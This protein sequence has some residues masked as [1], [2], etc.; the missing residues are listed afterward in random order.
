V[1][2][3]HAHLPQARSIRVGSAA[4]LRRQA[5]A[6]SSD[7]EI[8]GRIPEA[9]ALRIENRDQLIKSGVLRHTGDVAGLVI[10]K[11]A[12]FPH[13]VAK[14]RFSGLTRTSNDHRSLLLAR[15]VELRRP[16]TSRVPYAGRRRLLGS[17]VLA[18]IA[19]CGGGSVGNSNS[20]VVATKWQRSA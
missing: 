10:P 9:R 13:A 5:R 16:M 11:A 18:P 17:A 15:I 7:C 19:A 14:V 20:Q 4:L 2:E 3:Q 8:D 1:A 6:N 12:Y